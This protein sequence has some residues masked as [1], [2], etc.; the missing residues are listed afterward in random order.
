MRREF[1]SHMGSDVSLNRRVRS[2]AQ[3]KYE[4]QGDAGVGQPMAG[5][6]V[7]IPAYRSMGEEA[8]DDSQDRRHVE[9]GMRQGK[10]GQRAANQAKD[11]SD[12]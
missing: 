7:G 5:Q 2:A 3:S 12:C 9:K 11:R 10:D 8:Q 4:S 1:F 6:H